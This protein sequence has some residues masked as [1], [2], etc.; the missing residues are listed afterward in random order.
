MSGLMVEIVFHFPATS[1]V[2][3]SILMAEDSGSSVCVCVRCINL[4]KS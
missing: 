4:R 3:L 2:S 1:V